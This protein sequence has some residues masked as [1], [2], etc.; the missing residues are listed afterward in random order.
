M[1]SDNLCHP[2]LQAPGFFLFKP[3]HFRQ[4]AYLGVEPRQFTFL[5]TKNFTE[6]KLG[7]HKNHEN[8]N[9]HH[10]QGGQYI[11]ISGPGCDGACISPRSG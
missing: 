1:V 8:K 7:H 5:T 11:H 9:H 4:L 6:Q 3:Q 10:Q 2:G